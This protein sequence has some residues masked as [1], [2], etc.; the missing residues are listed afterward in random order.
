[1][2]IRFLMMALLAGAMQLG[3]VH[4]A[5]VRMVS[6]QEAISAGLEL[7]HQ[8]KASDHQTRAADAGAREA[9][10]HYYPNLFF[11]ESVSVA[12]VPTRT[13]MMKLDQG[14]FTQNDFQINNLNNPKSVTDFRTSLTWEQPLFVAAAYAE[15]R[16]AA[17]QA[18]QQRI[19]G[20]ATREQVAFRIFQTCLTVLKAKAHLA[21]VEQAL[22]EV[23]ESRRLA[24]VRLEAGLGL[25]SDEM[26]ADTQLAVTEQQ[27]ISAANNLTLARMQLALLT[28]AA[29]GEELD[30]LPISAIPEHVGPLEAL[31]QKT[32]SGHTSV[33]LAK[34][35]LEQAD[36]VRSAAR[37]AYL[38][39]ISGAASYQINDHRNPFGAEHD[40]WMAGLH[41]RWN[42]FDGFRR[43][44]RNEKALASRS[45]GQEQ[46]EQTRREVQYHLH[47]AWLRDQESKQ[48]YKV[49]ASSVAAAEEAVRLVGRRFENALATML[50]LLDAQSAL[51]QSRALLVES[52]T[53]RLLARGTL[54]Y[55]S[56]QFLQEVQKW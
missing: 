9:S 54:W 20:T 24:Q 36:A 8:I 47:A 28:G 55:A 49:A 18:E 46:L 33:L 43:E 6:L 22:A 3:T 15:R 34:S 32:L 51:H 39:N 26:R 21:S 10:S 56:G 31:T 29:V 50:E 53:D 16:V 42:L 19:A 41:L 1:M 35:S 37:S 17:R 30:V 11:E 45:A 44:N 4:A 27:R 2:S 23:R 14:R 25:K 12:N 38:P 48:R 40:S 13:F 5:E 7:N 52:E